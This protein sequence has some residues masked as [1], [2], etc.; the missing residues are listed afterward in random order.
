MK[1]KKTEVRQNDRLRKICM[2]S[3]KDVSRQVKMESKL[4]RIGVRR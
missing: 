1:N 4:N 3:G 2:E